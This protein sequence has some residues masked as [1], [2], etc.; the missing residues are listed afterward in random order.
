MPQT[1]HWFITVSLKSE[2]GQGEDV[3]P[4]INFQRTYGPFMTGEALHKALPIVRR[5]H[6]TCHVYIESRTLAP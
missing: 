6:S 5:W 4:Y 3:L 1:Q 2:W